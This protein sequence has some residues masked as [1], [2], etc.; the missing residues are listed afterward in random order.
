[1]NLAATDNRL[2]AL[3]RYVV[4]SFSLHLLWEVLQLPL[5]ALWST[6][7][8]GRQVFAVVHC[9]IGDIMISGLS[10]MA[11]LVVVDLSRWPSV[12]MRLVWLFTL[13]LGVSYTIYSE[14]LNVNVRGSWAYA[15]LMPTVPTVGT[16][17]SPLLQ[18][19]AVPTF[20]LWFVGR[21]A[22]WKIKAQSVA[23][24]F[25]GFTEVT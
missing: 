13:L 6:A 11:A 15:P 25:F 17:L 8:I 12:G 7:S 16:G 9:T 20:T 19:L 5:Y 18:W 10:L 23:D 24:K 1:M 14:W 22:P 4:M 21:S 3:R 2:V